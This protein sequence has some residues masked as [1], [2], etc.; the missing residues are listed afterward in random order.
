[1]SA[2]VAPA[3]DAHTQAQ[4]PGDDPALLKALQTKP[5]IAWPTI[6]LFYAGWIVGAGVGYLTLFEN[7]MPLW[8]GA[9]ISGIAGYFLFSPIHDALH[10][11]VSRYEWINDLVAIGT[12]SIMLPYVNHHMLRWGHMQHHRFTNEQGKD[13][14]RFLTDYWFAPFTTWAFFELFYVPDYWRE[15]HTRPAAEVRMVFAQLILGLVAMAIGT[16]I[17]GL[18]M[19]LY[20][21]IASRITLWLIVAVFVYLPHQPHTV[22]QKDAPYQASLLRGGKEWLLTP[23]MAYQNWHLVHHL[24]PTIPFYRYK[25]AWLAREAFH[26]SKL[27]ARV[28]AFR[29]APDHAVIEEGVALA[30]AQRGER[31]QSH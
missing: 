7:A 20:W 18:D 23:L 27:P 28:E 17:M 15:R 30:R 3:I 6:F 29:L 8:L 9:V 12:V 26:E 11:S 24:Y 4:F 10:R 22:L 16:W 21:F 31:K 13:P 5:D 19:L 25:K 2:T 1:M 14:D